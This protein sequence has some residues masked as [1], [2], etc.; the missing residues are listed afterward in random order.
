[1]KIS[2]LCPKHPYG[3]GVSF[4]W[5][6]LTDFSIV[7]FVNFAYVSLSHQKLVSWNEAGN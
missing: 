6:D 5:N 2:E 1:M 4:N 7:F 3:V